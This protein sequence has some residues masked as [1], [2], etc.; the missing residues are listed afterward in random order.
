MAKLQADVGMHSDPL[1]FIYQLHGGVDDAVL[2]LLHPWC[3][4]SPG[5]TKV[6]RQPGLCGLLQRI[7]H[8]TTTPHG[9]Q[10]ALDK[11]QTPAHPLGPYFLTGRGKGS[12]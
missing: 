11:S 10:S 5:T 9:T 12:G 7:Q 3:H 8:S 2:T 1:Q 4:H 6:P